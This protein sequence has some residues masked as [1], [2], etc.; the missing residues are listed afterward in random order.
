MRL[1]SFLVF[2]KNLF[3]H[4]LYVYVFRP[5]SARILAFLDK[6]IYCKAHGR[7][8]RTGKTILATKENEVGYKDLK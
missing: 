8:S 5:F 6:Y 2:I 7:T 1:K 3:T 4:R